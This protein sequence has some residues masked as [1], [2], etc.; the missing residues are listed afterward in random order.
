MKK[1]L[2]F[3]PL[4]LGLFACTNDEVVNNPDNGENSGDVETSY[5]SVNIV[6]SNVSGTKADDKFQYGTEEENLVNSIRFYFFNEWGNSVAV[7][8]NGACY[9]D[10]K[11]DEIKQNAT[12]EPGTG[13]S[14]ENIEKKVS[15]VI[16]I[17][18]QKGDSKPCFIAAVLNYESADLPTPTEANPLNMYGLQ[19]YIRNYDHITNTKYP[20]K[21]FVMSSTTY[22]GED[23]KYTQNG[24]VDE[25]DFS[26]FKGEDGASDGEHVL[27]YVYSNIK[28]TRLEA[29][30]NPVTI[31]VERV[32]AKVSADAKI[33]VT[34]DDN[35][36]QE[37]KNAK[38]NHLDSEGNTVYWVGH[39]GKPTDAVT[40][41]NSIYVNFL[42]WNV[43]ATRKDSRLVKDIDPTWK[44]IFD[45]GWGNI[46][47]N[48]KD[49]Y[50]SYWAINPLNNDI[51]EDYIYG[52][53]GEGNALNSN[54]SVTQNKFSAN[55]FR[56]GK[57]ND[58]I[59]KGGY[60]Y[61][62][63]N[64]GSY[65]NPLINDELSKIIVAGQLVDYKGN[66]L[67]LVEWQGDVYRYVYNT[68]AGDDATSTINVDLL[69]AIAAD[70]D[71][72]FVNQTSEGNKSYE[73]IKGEDIQFQFKQADSPVSSDNSSEQR[74]YVT[75][76]LKDNTKKYAHYE[77]N[78]NTGKYYF[79]ENGA[80]YGDNGSASYQEMVKKALASVGNIKYWNS[81]YTYYWV[82]IKHLGGTVKSNDKDVDG[83][84]RYGV[85]RNHWYHYTF[86]SV[87]GLGVPV[88]DPS[89]DIYPETPKDPD[90]FYLAAEIE[91]LSWRMVNHDDE[92][93]GW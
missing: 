18:S 77:F 83:I 93:L 58:G 34:I 54:T 67:G 24:T 61:L 23:V 49:N 22:L 62:Q 2:F 14:Y 3:L 38:A 91:I 63:E 47:W 53:F 79:N 32:L 76:E 82:N 27:D 35:A 43:T 65:A 10:V 86:T 50:R 84:G 60:T 36:T 25:S 16:V 66:P 74:Y 64:A 9:Y 12:A 52:N 6:P 55:N 90:L 75:I 39:S 73:Q 48:D 80:N 46:T 15:A 5:L 51:K 30:A 4:A 72:Y 70:T 28:S 42:G 19:N 88:A 7:K 57:V 8:S 56:F 13:E 29:L 69:N 37:E 59:S 21:G 45:E 31:H 92:G 41:A 20:D 1:S 78:S 40:E 11:G 89:K 33:N 68:Y 17:E 81:G 26:N 87:K 71:L 44:S 85:V